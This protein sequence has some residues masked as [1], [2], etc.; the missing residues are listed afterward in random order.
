MNKKIAFDI[1]SV[2]YYAITLL[3]VIL[4]KSMLAMYSMAIGMLV[5]SVVCLTDHLKENSKY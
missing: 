2:I 4:N 5:G 1:I 3:L